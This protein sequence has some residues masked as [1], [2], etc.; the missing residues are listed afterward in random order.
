MRWKPEYHEKRTFRFGKM[1]CDICERAIDESVQ[2]IAYICSCCHQILCAECKQI[3]DSI[4]NIRVNPERT[5]MIE[6]HT[7]Y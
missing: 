7:R 1:K 4:R 6:P 5:K 3:Q 2:E